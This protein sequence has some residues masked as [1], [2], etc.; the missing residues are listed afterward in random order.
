MHGII[1]LTQAPHLPPPE[2]SNNKPSR[3]KSGVN[4]SHSQSIDSEVELRKIAEKDNYRLNLQLT[5][6]SRELDQQRQ[7]TKEVEADKKR[8]VGEAARLKRELRTKDEEIAKLVERS[9][10]LVK[11]LQ[12]SEKKGRDSLARRDTQLEELKVQVGK[13]SADNEKL[14]KEKEDV[15]RIMKEEKE[16]ERRER[17]NA[18]SSIEPR[19]P[20]IPMPPPPIPTNIHTSGPV[21]R[22]P[23]SGSGPVLQRRFSVG[24]QSSTASG[25]HEM[26]HS[27]PGSASRLSV[28]HE[29]EDAGNNVNPSWPFP[30]PIPPPQSRSPSVTPHLLQPTGSY[31]YGLPN[32]RSA[33]GSQSSIQINI[34]PPVS[35]C[36][37][38]SLSLFLNSL[39]FSLDLLLV[40][41]TKQLIRQKLS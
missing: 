26:L 40:S 32:G 8:L 6:R 1:D 11:Q 34:E 3:P 33:N 36:A 25:R 4:Q 35:C 13:L 12:T 18:A 16:K 23:S 22:A 38:S 30:Q 27:P 20:Y 21:P 10:T 14:Q 5:E 37:H 41:T 39:C 28:I 9:T 24:S 15:E 31:M 29:T 2:D 7:K 17:D 19:I